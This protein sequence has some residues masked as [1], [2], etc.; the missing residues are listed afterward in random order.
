MALGFDLLDDVVEPIR[1]AGFSRRV[2][3]SGD[4]WIDQPLFDERLNA[5]LEAV[6]ELRDLRGV[7]IPIWREPIV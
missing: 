5:I 4:V 7:E 1:A 3:G 6:D 2:S